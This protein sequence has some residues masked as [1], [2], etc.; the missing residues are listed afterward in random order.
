VDF[1]IQNKP[2]DWLLSTFTPIVG[3][4]VW[5]DPDKFGMI[6]GDID[7]YKEYYIV[8]YD[9]RSGSIAQYKH[10]SLEELQRRR[11]WVHDLLIEQCPRKDIVT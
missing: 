1:I 10:I 4:D 7:D 3:T 11:D 9:E 2:D 8:G 6:I 5:D